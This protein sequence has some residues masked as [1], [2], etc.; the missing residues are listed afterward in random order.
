M[1][2]LG[3]NRQIHL[4]SLNNDIHD[5]RETRSVS[6]IASA[7]LP[8]TVLYGIISCFKRTQ[9]ITE[10]KRPWIRPFI[11]SLLTTT[12]DYWFSHHQYPLQL[13]CPLWAQ[14]MEQQRRLVPIPTEQRLSCWI[15]GS[16]YDASM[17]IWNSLRAVVVK[18]A[19]LNRK[20]KLWAGKE[21]LII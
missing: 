12:S 18:N 17:I 16:K 10:I 1:S 5:A 8:E 6:L 21:Q 4:K 15:F 19:P 20:L 7:I 14:E 13:A 9:S 11:L 3:V 2:H